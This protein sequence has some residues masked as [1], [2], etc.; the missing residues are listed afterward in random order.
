MVVDDPDIAWSSI[1]PGKADA[2]LVVDPDTVLPEPIAL[3]GFQPIPRRYAQVSQLAST[4][5]QAKLPEC[6]SL[7]IRRKLSASLAGPDALGFSIC[8]T[9]DHGYV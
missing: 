6:H 1:I 5:H 9:L 3:E 7:Y 2:P 8:E 4:V